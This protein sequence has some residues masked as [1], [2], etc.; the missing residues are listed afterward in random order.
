MED[1]R[2]K[3]LDPMSPDTDGADPRG[4]HNGHGAT[5]SDALLEGLARLHEIREYIA[6]LIEVK[7]DTI[8]A[9]A[10]TLLLYL[11][12]GVL[13]LVMGAAFVATS[14]VLL[15]LGIAHGL[16]ELFHHAWIGEVVVA[17]VVLGGVAGALLFG[18]MWLP[19]IMQKQLV[20]KYEARQR[21]QRTEFGR[22][23]AQQARAGRGGTGHSS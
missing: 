2:A 16:G 12:A 8:K 10:R 1:S 5:P 13:G 9:T 22:D 17:V 11:A 14:A 19:H 6:Y 4:A 23:V 20:S 15:L 18:M 21:K 7:L 3:N